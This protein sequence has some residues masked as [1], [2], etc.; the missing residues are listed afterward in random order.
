MSLPS[1]RWVALLTLGALLALLCPDWLWAQTTEGLPDL[2]PPEET[3]ESFL[4]WMIRSSGMIGVVIMIMSFYMIAL[5]VWMGKYYRRPVAIPDRLVRELNELLA[6]KR[7]TEA[8]QRVTVD[9]SF[10]G[11][12]LTAGVRKLASGT[13]AATKAMELANDEVTMEMEHRTTYLATMGTLGPMIGLVGTVYGMILSFQEIARAGSSPQA[14]VLAA[15]ISTA[16]FATLEGIALA[17]PAIYF[18]AYFRNRIARISLEVAMTSES[19]LEQF[20]PGVRSP[21]PLAASA[22]TVTNRSAL[23]PG[24]S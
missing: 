5:I 24:E 15:G 17:I 18:Y 4:A 23:P 2:S 13:S 12:V 20:S 6:Q 8:Y 14:S 21:H 16:L 9:N 10:L 22:V 11:R 1:R 19:L 7:F 3:S